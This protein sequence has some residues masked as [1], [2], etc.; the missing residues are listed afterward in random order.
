[1]SINEQF[2]LTD[3]QIDAATRFINLAT[4]TVLYIVKS[5]SLVG[6]EYRVIWNKDF[7]RF[8]CECKA[9]SHG[10]CC[11]HVRSALANE[12]MYVQAKRDE[13]EARTRL[14]EAAAEYERLMMVPPTKPGEKDVKAAV[15]RN[16]PQ[17]FSLL[18]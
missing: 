3:E 15:K 8:A 2:N 4:R 16:Q 1:M 5:A 11:W 12:L 14:E 6:K 7:G 18:R 10:M 13:A 17:G 9:S